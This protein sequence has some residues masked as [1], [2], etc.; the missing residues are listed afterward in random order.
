[1]HMLSDNKKFSIFLEFLNVM[2]KVGK[3]SLVVSLGLAF[4]LRMA[5]RCGKILTQSKAHNAA[6]NFLV[7]CTPLLI[8][9]EEFRRYKPIVRQMVHHMRRLRF[10]RMYCAC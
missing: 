8:K 5:R 1:M 3:N 9:T 6:K 4:G 10:A 2:S 7:N